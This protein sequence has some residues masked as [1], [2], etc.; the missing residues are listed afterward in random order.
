[1]KRAKQF[2][3]VVLALIMIITSLPL[4]GVDLFTKAEA[5]TTSK[6]KAGDVIEFGSFPQSEVTDEVLLSKLNT[7]STQWLSYGYYSGTG[8][9]AD[10]QMQPNSYMR[11][12]DVSYNGDRYRAVKF[13][14]YRPG[15]TGG[16][17][18]ADSSCQDENGYLTNRVY[19]FVFEP[20]RWKIL[21]PEQG[22]V[23]SEIILD[24][25]AYNN[26]VYYDGKSGYY[27]DVNRL[28]AANN[29]EKS[30]INKWLNLDFVNTALNS[31]EFKIK[32]G[33][34]ILISSEEAR[35]K[36][37]GFN[38]QRYDSTL[39]SKYS[40][41]SLCQGLSVGGNGCASWY[42]RSPG[43]AACH[44]TFVTE[45]GYIYGFN[46]VNNILGIRP[47]MKISLDNVNSNTCKLSELTSVDYLAFSELSYSKDL[48]IGETIKTSLKDIWNEKWENEIYYNELYKNIANWKIYKYEENTKNG[49][50]AYAFINNDNEVVI[51]Y[52]GSKPLNETWNDD[53]INDWI[54][55]DLPM[56]FGNYATDKTQ[57]YDVIDFYE[58]IAKNNSIKTISTTGHSL[59]GAW[60]NVVSVYSGCYCESFNAISALDVVYESYPEYMGK[61]FSGVNNYNFIDHV[62]QFDVFAGAY[63]LEQKNY[64]VHESLYKLTDGATF[65][66]H[67]LHSMV[68]KSGEKLVLT[69]VIETNKHSNSFRWEMNGFADSL[70]CLSNSDITNKLNLPAYNSRA[71]VVYGGEND[72]VFTTGT[73]N[74]ILIGGNGSDSLDGGP[75]NDKYY[76]FKGDGTDTIYDVAGDN[77]LY[78]YDFNNNDVITTETSGKQL[79]VKCNGIEI[80]KINNVFL[81]NIKAYNKEN[82]SIYSEKFDFTPDPFPERVFVGC[83]VNV[84]IIDDSNGEIV[85]T[86][87]DKTEGAYYTDYGFFYIYKD[88]NG[89]YV[90]IADLFD[91]Y[92]ARIIGTET[93]TM[94][95]S[96]SSMVDGS[97]GT[98]YSSSNVPVTNNLVAKIEEIDNNKYL[99]IDNDGDGVFETRV[100]LTEEKEINCTISIR[101]PSRTTI[102][103][104][105]GIILHLNVDGE[106]P[107]GAR[108]KWL[109]S[110][111]NFYAIS[112]NNDMNAGI[113]AEKNGYTT[114]TVTLYDAE[115]NIISQD[116]ITMRSKSGLFDRI[117]GFFRLLFGT[118][119]VYEY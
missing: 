45:Y 1:M 114:F 18:D 84:E 89:D 2:L 76:Y 44:A 94:N 88:E 83:P 73:R 21:D 12:A 62:N 109:K 34:I 13:I 17:S 71:V 99:I 38:P 31:N 60:A 57:F 47:L 36:D 68:Q 91:G 22:L 43:H 105:D 66:N 93:G 30:S 33:D 59:G 100:Q 107:E 56:I 79:S 14:K 77:T 103:N 7:L 70:L 87:F 64:K 24:A 101:E 115:D 92:S 61:T 52:R 80:V 78:L 67:S 48:K 19:W 49:F 42:F 102:R 97:L 35:N 10:G 15:Q 95:V 81:F 26:T 74:D 58:D 117:G 20:I 72:D 106:I 3:S 54:K 111:D 113:E 28:D 32:N 46:N 11:Y 8:N 69:D 63:G 104:R 119:K 118:T 27:S 25:Q 108:I 41:Y 50:A 9:W 23:M 98:T 112:F 51:A 5:T 75:G 39:Q 29:Y 82:K 86:L 6:Y 53:T 110:N 96:V 116:S 40:D 37:Y 55:N 85:L 90:K 4:I 65:T 16:L